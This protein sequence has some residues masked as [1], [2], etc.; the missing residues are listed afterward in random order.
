MENLGDGFDRVIE[1]IA[2]DGKSRLLGMGKSGL[3]CKK[4]LPRFQYRNAAMF[5]HRDSLHGD[6][7]MLQKVTL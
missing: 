5:L 7:G 3:I 1:M 6:L 2:N 4:S